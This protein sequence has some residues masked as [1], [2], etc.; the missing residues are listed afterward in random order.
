MQK[1]LGIKTLFR[2]R[3]AGHPAR[4]GWSAKLIRV[5]KLTIVLIIVGCLQVSA[6]GF[7]QTVTLTVKQAKLETIFQEIRRQTGYEF[8]Y[9]SQMLEA[10]R[11]VDIRVADASV[12]DVLAEIFLDQP[13]TFTILDGKTIVVRQ[14]PP[15][16]P[17]SADSAHLPP[18]EIHGRVT[19][20][21][22]VPLSGANVIIKRTRRGTE[23]NA[24]G[25]FA[26]KNLRPDDLMMISFIGYK[27]QTVKVGGGRDFPLVMEVAKNELDK[28]VIQAYGTTT[29]RLNTGNITTVTSEQIERQPVMNP[30]AALQGQVPGLVITQD[31]SYASSPFK[32]EI[33]GR[34][35]LNPTLPSEPLYIIDGVP[36]TV[37]NLGNGGNYASG[38]FGIAQNG[39]NGPAG[40]Q[41][42]LFSI[43]P[44]D[45]ESVSVLKDAD[46]TSIYGSRGAN[47]VIIITT[48]KGK[49]GKTK[50]DINAYNGISEVTN[51]YSMLNTQQYLQMRREAFK[52][53]NIT[54]AAGTAY[55]LLQ[56][57][58]TRYTDWQKALWGRLGHTTDVQLDL[59]GG[60][61]QTT[62]RIG[63]S[64]HKQTDIMT[65]SGADQRGSVQFNL[66]HRS[67][68]QRLA[69][70]FTSTYSFTQSDLTSLANG[71]T[72][73]P[74]APAIFD[75][76][77]HLNYAGWGALNSPAIQMFPY[78]TLLQP[79][80]A[81]TG[82][83]NS[84]LNLQYELLK[85]LKIS[86]SLGYSTYHQSQVLLTPIA[87][88][89]PATNPTGSSEFGNNN[90][91]NT[92]V[93]PN[94]VYTGF[95]SKGK[96]D[97]L[98]GGSAQSVSQD[99]NTIRGSG[100]TNDN[101]LHSVANAPT[102]Q[103]FNI[104]GQ[105]K[106]AA[107]FSRLNYNWENKYIINL[108]A[109]RD[110]SSRFG[111]GK[112]FGDFASAG[113]AWI[114]TEEAW[115]NGHFHFLSFGKL[116]GSYGTTGSDQIP[117]YQYLSQWSASGI[118]PYEPGVAS[119]VPILLANPD[120]VW[121]SNHKLE[122][123]LDLGFFHDRLTLE[124]ARYQNRCGNQLV[125]FI[126]PAITGF[127]TVTAN[128]PALVQNTGWE[129][130]FNGKIIDRKE[131]ILSAYF[132]I[133]INRN[134]LI[135]YPNLAKSSYAQIF[136]IGEPLNI[137]RMLHYTGVDPQ[138]GQYSFLDRNHNGSIDV[139][140]RAG[141]PND[142]YDKDLSVKFDGGMG[143]DLQYKNWQLNAFFQ[144]RKQVL[145]S[146]V[147]G[148]YPGQIGNQSTEV[149]SHWQK[150]GDHAEFARYTTQGTITDNAFANYSD[151][152]YSDGSYIRLRNV[153]IVYRMP[154]RLMK[155]SGLN[156][157]RVFFR[158]ENLF[159]LTKYNGIDPDSP[160]LGSLPP[161]KIFTGGLQFNF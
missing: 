12:E 31:N 61:K 158:G 38:S 146:S 21:Q 44:A 155:G 36:L 111:P 13:F 7:S 54:M 79:Y 69:T 34:S 83:L 140:Y 17:S 92:I 10:A 114:F 15:P 154:A 156:N 28:V 81:Q 71:S 136:T 18:G 20:A 144:F 105:Y 157:C 77:G 84:Q 133:G 47:G 22:G 160:G 23:T 151:G 40:G 89:N 153:S 119:Y 19:N 126:L 113:A 95:I 145:P 39:F 121:Q 27:T 91:N 112:Q 131:F 8:L 66:S 74:D 11:R 64:Y 78:Y 63:G 75:A 65:V 106:Y 161:S 117:S 50:L 123:A 70:S 128:F 159:L 115:F 76:Q 51:H 9:N 90:A 135:A 53:D 49:P 48:K 124:V 142:L 141:V 80:T 98:I 43:N 72:L 14:K 4:P 125:P 57:D 85:G 93:E 32:V 87:S 24:N 73:P 147:Y 3:S 29:A 110:G 26:L 138:T 118:T 130:K 127:T 6:R 5:M 2:K 56:W 88:L 102:T 100:Y 52:N 62:F 33:R 16:A 46:A 139:T 122:G 104:S 99:G 152:A 148:V 107:A 25:E 143:M 41:S 97:F 109:R 37:L 103:G 86:T 101:L 134:K 59:S 45:I 120:L 129:T 137:K 42:P 68:D 60:D 58:T 1:A 149:L 94:L 35:V 150:P 132:N 108:S 116:R 82:F 96:I 67:L 30:L 55:D